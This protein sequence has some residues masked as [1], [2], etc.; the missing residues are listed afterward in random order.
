[1]KNNKGITLV[2]LVIT[3][4]V[5]AILAGV[6]VATTNLVEES[7]RQKKITNMKLI[8]IKAKIIMEKVEFNN[9]DTSMY[10]GT[11]LSTAPNKAQI[12][13]N[14]LDA[15]EQLEETYY[16]YD[17]NTLKSI[18]LEGINLE[19]G[20]VYIVD[21]SDGDVIAPEG[22]KSSSGEIVYRLSEVNY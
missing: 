9:N 13:G 8:Q 12:A 10:V 1:M 16:I 14:A 6:T 20:E 15:N 7:V 22:L 4:V 19:E 17:A 5:M 18:N 2:T 11:K 21:Y 3:I